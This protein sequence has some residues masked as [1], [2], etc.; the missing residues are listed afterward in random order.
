[1]NF[2]NTLKWQFDLKYNWIRQVLEPQ[3]VIGHRHCYSQKRTQQVY[4][5]NQNLDVNNP[6][7]LLSSVEE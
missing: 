2:K 7:E 3:L 1:M 6:E 4:R 5:N